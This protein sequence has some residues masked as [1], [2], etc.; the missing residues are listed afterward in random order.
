MVALQLCAL[1][2]LLLS[3]SV[4]AAER[5]LVLAATVDAVIHPVSAD[6][7]VGAIRRA[8]AE[9]AALLVFTLRTPGGL[10]D[11]TREIT[12]AMIAA[13]TPVAVFIAPAG[14]RAASA[15]FII[16]MASDLAAMAPGTHIGAAH[17]V[18]GGGEKVDE[19]MSKKMASDVAA[20]ARALAA[21][22]GRNLTLVDQAVI[23]SRSYTE[24][25]ASSANP[26]LVEVIA[27][28]LDD[29]LRKID[30]RT[31]RRFD[32][33]EAVLHTRDARVENVEMNWRQRLLS[34]IAHPQ[35]AYILF[36]LG[37]LGLTIELW[38]PGSILP[39]V[40]GA[41]CLLLAFFAFSILPINYA[42][43]L[44]I[45][46]GLVLLILEVKFTSYGVLGVGGVT[47]LVVGSL[48]L[49]DRT[50]PDL[51]LSLGF[52]LP[53]AGAVSAIILFLVRLAVKAQRGPSVTGNEGMVGE[54]GRALTA[55]GPDEPGQVSAHGEIWNAR[56]DAPIAAGARVR[57]VGVDG[58]TLIVSSH[59]SDAVRAE[60][61]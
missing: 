4:R 22:R 18:S 43:L 53:I 41:I 51:R 40:A 59:R 5:P 57:I 8:D 39:G 19:T 21:H 36:T 24:Q 52:V 31:I 34:A 47:S 46:F 32:G 6:Y 44:L 48:M 42:G 60:A 16:T 14:S 58:L 1:A 35:V 12:T 56:A 11:S 9:G 61:P 55:V 50:A 13:R 33:R 20:S 17:P 54:L 15:G 37:T 38:N 25:E 28:D 3:A 27:T 23:E 10:V 7:M 29:L 45:L 2:A 30:G 26:P 49:V